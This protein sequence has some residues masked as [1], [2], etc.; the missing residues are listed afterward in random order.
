MALAVH[1]LAGDRAPAAERGGLSAPQLRRVTEYVEA[2][3]GEGLSLA[4]LARVA[5][6]SASHVKTLFKR[7]TRLPAHEY[8]VRPRVERA[9]LL[10]VRG[11]LSPAQVALEAGCSHQSHRALWTRR[12]LGVTPRAR[13]HPRA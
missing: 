6:V 11:E 8:V 9:K 2:H 13:L 10:L 4:R 12:V 7:S 1:L 3:L 5:G